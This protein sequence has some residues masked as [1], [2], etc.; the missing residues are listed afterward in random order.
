[1]RCFILFFLCDFLSHSL[2]AHKPD[3]T[4]DVIFFYSSCVSY[5]T[6][7]FFLA[8][9]L[10]MYL[11][12]LHLPHIFRCYLHSGDIDRGLK[13]FEDYMNSGKPPAVELYVVRFWQNFLRLHFAVNTALSHWTDLWMLN[14]CNLC[15]CRYLWREPWLGIL[16]RECILLKTRWYGWINAASWLCSWLWSLCWSSSLDLVSMP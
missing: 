15:G 3:G 11:Y 16:P 6:G 10:E 4:L 8:I 7:F 9:S 2:C 13:T 12:C 5:L 1:M 14:Y